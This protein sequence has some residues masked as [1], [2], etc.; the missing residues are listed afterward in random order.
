MN[1]KSQHHCQSGCAGEF[2]RRV[3]C[4]PPGRFNFK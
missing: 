3:V 4:C 2:V 1:L